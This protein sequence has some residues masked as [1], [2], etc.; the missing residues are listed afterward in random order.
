VNFEAGEVLGILIL[1]KFENYIFAKTF[2][3]NIYV[4]NYMFNSFKLQPE[5]GFK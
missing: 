1:A 4:V 3:V 2:L 5:D